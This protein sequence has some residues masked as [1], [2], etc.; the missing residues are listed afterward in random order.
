MASS[1]SHLYLPIVY[2]KCRINSIG[3]FT[4]FLLF[5]LRKKRLHSDLFLN[6]RGQNGV[7]L[8]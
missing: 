1:P 3:Y 8:L 7:I 4:L 6:F 5:I 2:H